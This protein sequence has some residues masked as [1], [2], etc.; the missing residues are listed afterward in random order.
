M[1]EASRSTALS[2]AFSADI[3]ASKEEDEGGGIGGGGN[4]DGN[5]LFTATAS[6]SDTGAAVNGG[7]GE[8]LGGVRVRTV[9]APRYCGA[10]VVTIVDDGAREA[11]AVAMAR[12]L[13]KR[14]AN[15]ERAVRPDVRAR[16]NAEGD[17][18]TAGAPLIGAL[19]QRCGLEKFKRGGSASK[20]SN[21]LYI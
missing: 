11:A 5:S 8:V 7:V 2:R 4:G 14:L 21:L 10:E 9:A 12:L 16:R 20:F 3:A 13:R 17:G 18:L 1:V 15:G 6:R 19:P